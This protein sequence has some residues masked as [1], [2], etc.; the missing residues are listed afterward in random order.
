MK[1]VEAQIK[2]NDVSHASRDQWSEK[3]KY[4]ECPKTERPVWLSG[5][6]YV[7]FSNYPVIGRPVLINLSGYR[8]D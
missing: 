1:R 6:K 7:R 3:E 5:R 4:S 2:V 8:I